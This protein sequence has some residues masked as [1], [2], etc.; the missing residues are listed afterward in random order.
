MKLSELLQ[1]QKELDEKVLEKQFS[2]LDE[3]SL[4]LARKTALVVEFFEFLNETLLFK[5]W[6]KK[7]IK[8]ENLKEEFIDIVHFT[9]SLCLIYKKEEEAEKCILGTSREGGSNLYV[10]AREDNK[11][12]TELLHI[13]YSWMASIHEAIQ[14]KNFKEW[15]GWLSWISV[16]M[17]LKGEEIKE[18]YLSKWKINFDRLESNS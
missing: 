12:R 18:N 11:L 10:L 15:L 4:L 8:L 1:Y 9:L 13:S 14:E 6:T 17:N 3:F 16:L 7:E 5:Y 2:S